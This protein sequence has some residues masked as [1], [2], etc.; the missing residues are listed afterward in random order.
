MILADTSIWVHHFQRGDS[1][2]ATLLD[3]ERILVHPH[4]IGEI[5]LGSL[6]DRRLALELLEELPL[7]VIARD[8]EV[9]RLIESEK[10]F[11]LGIGYVD[12]HL[13]A[14]TRLTP[15]ARLWTLDKRLHAAVARLSIAM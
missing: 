11:G 12:A 5:M 10:L 4:V 7:A 13:V 1:T 14:A 2:M 15:G 3:E 8:E 6:P 9:V